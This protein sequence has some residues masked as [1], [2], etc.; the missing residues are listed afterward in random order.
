MYF[1]SATVP[2]RHLSTAAVREMH[3]TIPALGKVAALR[4]TRFPWK[5][6]TP[7]THFPLP[8]LAFPAGARISWTVLLQILCFSLCAV[9]AQWDRSLRS[10]DLSL[11]VYT[12]EGLVPLCQVCVCVCGG[13]CLKD[14]TGH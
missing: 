12:K 11:P 10:L 14:L 8:A 1:S 2:A 3:H 9:R 6:P 4:A 7:L 13:W 5:A